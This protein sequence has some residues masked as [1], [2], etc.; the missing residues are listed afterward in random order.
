VIRVEARPFAA[1]VAVTGT[2]V[3]RSSVDVKA[4]TIGRVTRFPKEEG[5]AVA[6]GEAVVW[7]DAENYRLG[8]R[9]AETAV[10]V[11]EAA[12]ERAL[13]LETHSRQEM[14]RARNLL[15]SGGITDKEFK[16]AGVAERES[17]AQ[18]AL[19][20]AQL[21]Q[22]RAALEVARKRLRDAVIRAPVAGEIHRKFLN[23]GAYV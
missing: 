14:D 19:A 20:R 11:A 16:A 2:L 8:V 6:A 4:E 1:A 10:E 15:S 23:A 13:V 18:V 17:A 9:Q 12:L 5:D 3:S 21:E 7:V 22:A